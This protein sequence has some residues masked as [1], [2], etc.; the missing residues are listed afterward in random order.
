MPV[1]RFRGIGEAP[2]GFRLLSLSPQQNA[3]V[4]FD[5]AADFGKPMPPTPITSLLLFAVAA[6]LGAAGQLLYK[7]GVDTAGAGLI[8]QVLSV[9]IFLGVLC[10]TAV[11]I[12]FVAAFRIGGSPVALYP[13]YASTF[14]WVAVLSRFIDGTPITWIHVFGWLLLI[15]G[16]ACMNWNSYAG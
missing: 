11:M 10:Y 14:I 8:N 1:N 12:L 2:L 3:Q 15:A 6:F 9:R 16:M 7:S 4:L 5:P 13:V